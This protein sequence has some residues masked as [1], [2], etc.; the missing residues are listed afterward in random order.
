MGGRS[1]SSTS[2]NQTTMN[3]DRRVATDGG[4]IGI[5]SQG[6]V[7]LNVTA[8][9]AWELGAGIVKVAGDLARQSL[10]MTERSGSDAIRSAGKASD[11]IGKTLETVLESQKSEETQLSS[12]LLR[13][14]IP[15]AA[16]AYIAS[17]V[18]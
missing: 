2:T 11:T 5:S 3:T 17:R 13:I 10:D 1:S 6:S 16:L 18:F 7:D 14:G 15:A 9:E 8:D 12:Q 4:G